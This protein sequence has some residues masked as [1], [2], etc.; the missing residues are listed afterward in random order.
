L[1]VKLTPTELT[2][3]ELPPGQYWGKKWIIYA[4]L[5]IPRIKSE[6]WSL[7][8]TG[9][10]NKPLNFSY[11]EFLGLPMKKYKKSFFCVTR[12]SIREPE[13]EGVQIRF[14]AEMAQVKPEVRWVMFHCADGYTAPVPIEDAL[15]E[16]SIIALK[17]DGEPLKIEQGFP[18]RPF[19]PHL[20]GWKSAKWLTEI[21][22]MPDYADGYWEAYGYHE[23][24]SVV[25]EERFKGG[26]GRHSKRRSFGVA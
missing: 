18:A 21:E 24:G 16:E 23:R 7:K 8:M 19:I 9:L 1:E 14:L 17:L 26:S 11:Q 10:V 22:F 3:E 4:A 5:D 15:H 20:Y 25:V 6:E 12:W 2:E 13:W